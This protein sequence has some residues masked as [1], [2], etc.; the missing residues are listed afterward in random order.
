M[1]FP[2]TLHIVMTTHSAHVKLSCTLYRL[3]LSGQC[4]RARLR[5]SPGR[6]DLTVW[7]PDLHAGTGRWSRSSRTCGRRYPTRCPATR[8]SGSTWTRCSRATSSLPRWGLAKPTPVP[9]VSFQPNSQTSTVQV[10]I[11]TLNLVCAHA[12]TAA[13][14]ISGSSARSRSQVAGTARSHTQV[15]CSS[16]AA[17][18]CRLHEIPCSLDSTAHPMFGRSRGKKCCDMH[19]TLLICHGVLCRPPRRRLNSGSAPTRSCGRR[20]AAR[21][22]IETNP[23]IAPTQG[24]DGDSIVV[25]CSYRSVDPQMQSLCR[26]HPAE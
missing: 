11:S 22:V 3:V 23:T 2:S 24:W 8:A 17:R 7:P 12:D 4:S 1:P 25:M 19:G 13:P 15:K 26:P 5:F 6:D 21:T 18:T 14:Y 16:R 9:D 20:A 10:P